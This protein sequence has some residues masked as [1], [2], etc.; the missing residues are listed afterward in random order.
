MPRP[1]GRAYV[2]DLLHV[3]MQGNGRGPRISYTLAQLLWIGAHVRVRLWMPGAET[4]ARPRLLV[5]SSV[6]RLATEDDARVAA[7][8]AYLAELVPRRAHVFDTK[9]HGRL[10]VVDA[11]EAVVKWSGLR[12]EERGEMSREEWDRLALHGDVTPGKLKTSPSPLPPGLIL[13]PEP[14]ADSTHAG[15]DSWSHVVK[16]GATTPAR[17]GW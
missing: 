15:R 17:K 7:A 5:A 14:S 10:W 11:D 6:V 9:A 16:P 8:R 1:A 4:F 3:R 13:A 12:S 2:G